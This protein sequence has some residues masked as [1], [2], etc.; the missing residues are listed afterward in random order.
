MLTTSQGQSAENQLPQVN[1][2]PPMKPII[3]ATYAEPDMKAQ[4]K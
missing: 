4:P 3:S 2:M 1:S